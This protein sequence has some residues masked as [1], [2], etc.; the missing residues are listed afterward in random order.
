MNT[1][2]EKIRKALF[3]LFIIACCAGCKKADEE[4]ALKT[5]TANLTKNQTLK[6]KIVPDINGCLFESEN[7]LI[8]SVSSTGVIT[9]NLIGDTHII[10][11]NPEKG[12][13][14][15]CSVTVLP[16]SLLFREPYLIF[17]SHKK[18]IKDY[19]VRYLYG[20]ND[21][22]LIY[23]GENSSVAA[24]YYYLPSAL[25]KECDCL[26]FSEYPTMFENFISE[27][28][29]L[30]D[31]QDNFRTLMTPDSTV[32]VGIDSDIVI[33]SETFYGLFYIRFP[34]LKGSR[35]FKGGYDWKKYSAELKRKRTLLS[36]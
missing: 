17:N 24:V 13:T 21:S 15:K 14:A 8:A 30:L 9:G 26:M 1:T 3:C 36:E 16:L 33:D 12:F 19:E 18:E 4:L 11:T 34:D 28:Y 31:T 7:E 10:V 32:L 5:V 29:Y 35:D 2:V 6:L 22:L 23:V 27:R 20:E 25:Y